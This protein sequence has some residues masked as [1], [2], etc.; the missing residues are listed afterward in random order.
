MKLKPI[1]ND[2]EQADLNRDIIKSKKVEFFPAESKTSL[3]IHI[4][5]EVALLYSYL[6][7]IH[8]KNFK[9]FI[10]ILRKQPLLL[11][12]DFVPPRYLLKTE[13]IYNH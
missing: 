10:K 11:T 12:H 9:I 7:K 3:H 1:K 4:L 8:Q 13:D 6:K 2:Q 5:P